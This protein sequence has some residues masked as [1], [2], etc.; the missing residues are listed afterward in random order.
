[1]TEPK[2][3]P[4]ETRLNIQYGALETI[5]EKAMA[6][7]C[8]YKWFNQTLCQVNGSVVRLGVFE[9]EYHWHKHDDD[10]VFFY[11]VEGCTLIRNR[12]PGE[13]GR[14]VRLPLR[15]RS[16]LLLASVP[17]NK[18]QSPPEFRPEVG[19]RSRGHAAFF[20]VSFT[21]PTIF[22]TLPSAC[23]ATP[24]ASVFIFPVAFP[25]LRSARP[26]TSFILP[27]TSSLFITDTPRRRDVNRTNLRGRNCVG[28]LRGSRA[29]LVL[30]A[31]L[32]SGG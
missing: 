4:Y 25:S 30:V 21:L 14:R 9:G 31:I 23:R 16:T 6:D 29:A 22:C 13:C 28:Q 20:M 5:D 7:A 10:D 26:T 12:A 32:R 15:S 24:R 19:L 3:F 17:L 1:M 18:R 27:F 11:V 8:T 2:H